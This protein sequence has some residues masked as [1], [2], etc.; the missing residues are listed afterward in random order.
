MMVKITMSL[1]VVDMSISSVYP[2]VA[3]W[4]LLHSGLNYLWLF[5]ANSSTPSPGK[6]WVM[7]VYF[8]CLI[9]ILSRGLKNYKQTFLFSIVAGG[10]CGLSSFAIVYC[11][12]PGV[13]HEQDDRIS[14]A[15]G[16]S[17]CLIVFY[18]A[19]GLFA[20]LFRKIIVR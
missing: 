4:L 9:L 12:F 3:I 6:E 11:C 13:F 7:S 8:I 18:L 5:Y 17:L 15:L 2:I 10:V 19:L 16:L 1:D 20:Q 14:K